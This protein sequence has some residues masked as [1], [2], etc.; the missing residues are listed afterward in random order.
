M[1]PRF[2]TLLFLENAYIVTGHVK[3]VQIVGK[4]DLIGDNSQPDF[5]PFEVDQIFVVGGVKNSAVVRLEFENLI[6][7]AVWFLLLVVVQYRCAGMVKFVCMKLLKI[8]VTK[9][10]MPHKEEHHEECKKKNLLFAPEKIEL[11]H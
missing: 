5:P 11:F 10:Q 6:D 1:K 8:V 9:Q 3:S 7:F 4:C 2:D